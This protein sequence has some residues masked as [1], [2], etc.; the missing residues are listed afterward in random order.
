MVDPRRRSGEWSW[1]AG[2]LLGEIWEDVL[3]GDVDGRENTVFVCG[4]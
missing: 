1:G 3:R 2:R 4:A